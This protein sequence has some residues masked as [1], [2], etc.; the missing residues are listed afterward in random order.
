MQAAIA[1]TDGAVGV[2]GW[3]DAASQPERILSV[4]RREVRRNLTLAY[5]LE[6][7]RRAG[8]V[9]GVSTIVLNTML[10]IL[11]TLLFTTPIG[12][13]AAIYLTEYTHQG[14]FVRILRFGTETLAGIPSIIFGLF[15]F[16]VFV[17]LLHLGIG[18]LSGTLTLTMMLLPT[19]IRTSEEAIR[20]APLALREGSL[21]L[22]ATKWQTTVLVVVPAAIPGILT[23][24]LLAVGRAVGETAAL[25]F[26]MGT[27][28]RLVEGLR[29]SARVLSVHLYYLLKEGISFDKAFATGTI[30][31]IIVL[32]VNLVTTRLIGR[33]NLLRVEG[34]RNG[35]SR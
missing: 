7:P 25:L 4:E 32:I 17:T 26:T 5:F 27:D 19:I 12:V 6:E 14:L 2:C 11:L 30:L 28:Y 23:G 34:G 29:S 16:I 35:R 33:M 10:M 15:G 24:V 1:A 20:G 13:G 22:G 9:G 18:L 21:A 3:S 31:V 8:K